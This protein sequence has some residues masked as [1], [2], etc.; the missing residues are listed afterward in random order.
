MPSF[1]FLAF[2]YRMHSW[3]AE[4]LQ[5]TLLHLK[6][7]F[8]SFMLRSPLGCGGVST[9]RGSFNKTSLDSM[10]KRSL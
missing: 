10:T 8:N 1:F 5:L 3:A 9:R 6:Y 2:V 4:L 7:S